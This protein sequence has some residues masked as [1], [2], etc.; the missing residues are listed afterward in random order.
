METLSAWKHALRD[1]SLQDLP[2]N[3][4]TNEYGQLVMSPQKPGH[5]LMQF[6]VGALLERVERPGRVAVEFAVETSKGVKLPDVVW[7]SDERLRDLPEGAEACPFAPEICVEVL[8][9]SNTRAEIDEKRNLYFEQGALE[10]W[11]C[12]MAGQMRFYGRN[13]EMEASALV[14]SFPSQVADG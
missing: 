14:L 2:Y 5:G 13:G 1:P 9:Q 3:I 7:I 11:T 8:S 4:E 6:R 12:D 10:V